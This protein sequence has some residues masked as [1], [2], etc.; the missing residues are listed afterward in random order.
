MARTAGSTSSTERSP[1]ARSASDR[2]VALGY[3]VG[4]HG[5]R[6]ALRVKLEAAGIEAVAQLSELWLGESEA[7][8]TALARALVRAEPGR[9]GEIRLQLAGLTDRGEA[10]ALRGRR[11]LARAAELE[12]LAPDELHDHQLV[13]CRVEDLEGREV[14]VVRGI[15]ST[16]APDLLVVETA[17]GREQLVPC[18]REIMR[19]VDLPAGRIV[20]DAPPGLLDRD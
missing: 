4:A 9:K 8:E 2:L 11:L 19:E 13:G 6:G 16:G 7:D 17:D 10:E 1:G 5:M 18:A 15:W 20:I 14:G 3:V 12:D